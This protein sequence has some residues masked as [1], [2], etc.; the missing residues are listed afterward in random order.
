MQCGKTTIAHALLVHL[1]A[2]IDVSASRGEADSNGDCVLSPSTGLGPSST[3]SM[4]T[5]GT[6]RRHGNDSSSLM[7]IS[8][9]AQGS[10]VAVD[11]TALHLDGNGSGFTAA[12][13][14]NGHHALPP[15]PAMEVNGSGVVFSE[16]VAGTVPLHE[17]GHSDGRRPV[18][19]ASV[20]S[21]R[22]HV[23]RPPQQQQRHAR[24]SASVPE[25]DVL[26]TQLA[27]AQ[28]VNNLRKVVQVARGSYGAWHYRC[29]AGAGAVWAGAK[30]LDPLMCIIYGIWKT[31]LAL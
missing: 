15:Q 31:L 19:T 28:N 5:N 2:A 23:S 13:G 12:A 8:L 20:A 24:H 25:D 6:R 14:V 17:E 30:N 7:A 16:T 9:D 10:V 1:K 27:E 29:G 22:H 18:G 3:P 21:P 26:M 4:Q 11:S